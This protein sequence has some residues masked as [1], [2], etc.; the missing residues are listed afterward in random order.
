M[1]YGACD[2]CGCAKHDCECADRAENQKVSRLLFLGTD[3]QLLDDLTLGRE[4]DPD[5]PHPRS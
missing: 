1:A 2:D 5:E 4:L 3:Q